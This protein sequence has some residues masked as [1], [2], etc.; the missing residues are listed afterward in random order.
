[1]MVLG[2]QVRRIF[3]VNLAQ[4]YERVIQPVMDGLVL[5]PVLEHGE[6]ERDEQRRR[7]I[8]TVA[9]R[10]IAETI[11]FIPQAENPSDEDLDTGTT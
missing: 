4:L 10:D 7:V 5:H 2:E 11:R 3:Q 8:G 1:M 9:R 6:A